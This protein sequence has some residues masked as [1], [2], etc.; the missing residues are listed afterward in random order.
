MHLSTVEALSQFAQ[1]ARSTGLLAIDTEF[2]SGKTYYAKLCLIQLAAGGQA[3][4]VDPL[5]L[6]DLSP[7]IDILLDERIL[8]IMHAASQDMALLSRLCG[9]PPKPV[10]DTQVAATLAGHASQTGYGKL[11]AALTGVTLEKSESFTD[12]SRRPLTDKQVRYALDD[13]VYLEP[14]YLALKRELEASGRLGWLAD[15]FEALSNPETYETPLQELYRS[16]KHATR[17]N[18]RQLAILREVAAWRET[19]AQRRNL[20]RQWVLKDEVLIELARRKPATPEALGE[21]RD[22]NPRS[23]GD[24]VRGLLAAINAGLAVPNNELPRL[25]HRPAP[26]GNQ[27][28]VVK[29]MGALVR[30]RAETHGI[31]VP[32]LAS[33]SDLEAMAS[34]DVKDNPLMHGWR[35]EMIGQELLRLLD[36]KLSMSVKNGVV[37]VTE[38]E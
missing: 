28:G 26:D 19:E 9:R 27:E 25:S 13:V 32:L 15:D 18:G 29:L 33:Q 16:I 37:V 7:L 20:P 38:Q 2:L 11:V 31:A 34:G 36:G 30:L 22:L 3:A 23:L 5:A 24:Q 6:K 10:F 8:K 14:M 4:Y 1:E 17:L 21:L 35:R 12:W